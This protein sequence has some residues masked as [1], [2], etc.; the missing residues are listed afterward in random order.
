MKHA[1]WAALWLVASSAAWP[2][3]AP[4]GGVVYRCPGPPILYTDQIGEQEAKDKNCRTIEGAPVTIVQMP[5]PA[6]GKASPV[7]G[8]REGK[9]D[10]RGDARG[11]GKVDPT[12][13]RQRD[14]DARKLLEAELKREEARL[15]ELQKAFNNGEPERQGD[16]R[17]Y[18]RYLDRVNE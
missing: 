12:A 8:S 18:Q 4:K 5:K 14:S 2:Q 7:A 11:D 16:E 9:G 10:A 6:S 17:N 15:A 3:A 1:L 13:Q